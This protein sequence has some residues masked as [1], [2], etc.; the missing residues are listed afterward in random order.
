MSE[1]RDVM[2]CD[3]LIVGGG[4]AG[5]SA[6]I[7]LMQLANAASQ[8][9]NVMLLEKG[10][11]VGAH[12]L[13]GAVLEPRALDELLPDWKALGAP[14][15]VPAQSDEFR[16]L[17]PSKSF[18]LPTPPQM[19]NHGNYIISLGNF[20]RWLGEQAQSL[21]VQIFPGFPAADVIIE[22]GVV[23]GVLTGE[24]GIGKD[25]ERKDS[26]QPSMEV[27]AKYTIFAEGCR[28][29][30][31]QRLMQTF[32]LRDG[33]DPQTYGIGIKELWEVE[34]EKSK[35]GSIVHSV[36][37]PMNTDTYG[38]SFLYH[39]D[40]N[41]VAIGFVVGLD[42]TNPHL[43]P[44]ME[45][46][47]FKTH[48]SVRPLLEGGKRISYGARALNEGGFQS[49][50]KLTM[51]GAVLTGCAAG[52]LN[53]P[54]IKGTHTAMKSGMVAA[55]S[56]FSALAREGGEE[57]LGYTDAIKASWVYGELESVRNIRPSFRYGLWAGL[58]YSAIDT[59][60]FKGK[61][62]WTLRHHADH[63]QLKR[64]KA[65]PRISYPKPDGVVSFDRLSSV[66]L[67]N[68]NHAEDQPAHLTLR[69]AKVPVNLNLELYD[70]PEQRF[71]PAG[72]YEFVEDAKGG[73]KLQINAQNCV[74]C[75]T[76]DIKDLSQ[77]IVWKT[78]EG[79]GGPNYG[80]M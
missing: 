50:P 53:V 70:G 64:A 14:L 8:S 77:N 41:Q 18:K 1:A 40:N 43:D 69:D 75:K 78:P 71:C 42:Y 54:K 17:T 16:F 5:L 52:F 30:L 28:G 26:Y 9:L 33:V 10:S 47:R 49:I 36:G 39:L 2:E 66:Y 56:I 62:P 65:A 73:K 79:G 35:P 37:W 21:G 46:Q 32:G 12:I 63:T 80:N 72:V 11:E 22:D 19:K 38:G 27:R 13:S 20:C 44:F 3:V 29:S 24:F 15:N 34:P 76:C 55:E 68:T 31:S 74:H 61:A 45:F 58:I 60:L 57:L 23:K 51:R 6:A 4:P 7:R 59:F 25:G 48:P 67:S